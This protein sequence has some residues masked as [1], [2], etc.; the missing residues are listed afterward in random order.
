MFLLFFALSP[1]E[2]DIFPIL[3]V[4]GEIQVHPKLVCEEKAPSLEQEKRCEH[5]GGGGLQKA[6]NKKENTKTEKTEKQKKQTV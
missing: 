5:W 2:S 6:K 3:E 1:F 4:K